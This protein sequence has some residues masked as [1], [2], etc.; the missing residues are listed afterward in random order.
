MPPQTTDE[1]DNDDGHVFMNFSAAGD[2]RDECDVLPDNLIKLHSERDTDSVSNSNKDSI[3]VATISGDDHITSSQYFDSILYDQLQ[4]QNSSH[5]CNSNNSLFLMCQHYGID[6]EINKKGLKI[7]FRMYL[8]QL[9]MLSERITSTDSVASP[10]VDRFINGEEFA[11]LRVFCIGLMARHTQEVRSQLQ[12]SQQSAE[13]QQVQRHRPI[14]A[15]EVHTIVGNR[16]TKVAGGCSNSDKRFVFIPYTPNYKMTS[17]EFEKHVKGYI[18]PVPCLLDRPQY[19]N[20]LTPFC[21]DDFLFP[22]E[23]DLET[24]VRFNGWHNEIL[25]LILKIQVSQWKQSCYKYI[26]SK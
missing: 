2:E 22:E 3:S 21:R 10:E 5:K 18:R 13:L 25:T 7:L 12:K 11:T 26:K 24:G 9:K 8:G 16:T 1:Y 6:N 19:L 20:Y 23:S 15:A 4:E 14:T 17:D